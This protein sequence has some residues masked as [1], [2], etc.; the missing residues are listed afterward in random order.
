MSDES[1]SIFSQIGLSSGLLSGRTLSADDTSA[2][3]I[4]SSNSSTDNELNA[5]LNFN[6]I[7]IQRN[8]NTIT[9]LVESVTF[10]L[11]AVNQATDADVSVSVNVDT[12]NIT[13][14][15]NEFISNFNNAYTYIKNNSYSSGDKD[16]RGAFVG[17]ST[18]RSLMT[19]LTNIAMGEVSGLQEDNFRY[20]SEIGIAFSPTGGL[21]ISDS[22]KLETSLKENADQ[23]ADLFNSENGIANSLY[24]TL[25]NYLGVDGSISNLIESFDNNVSYYTKRIENVNTSIDRSADV[26]RSQYENLQMQMQ[27]LIYSFNSM[28]AFSS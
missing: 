11:N 24:N 4:Y 18:A 22:T 17:D 10:N 21:S 2:G 9:D 6:G 13:K 1:G 27:T 25:E 19:T 15:I 3:F 26:L 14:D 23:V 16:S 28:S 12:E 7:N 5:K 20:L 8:S